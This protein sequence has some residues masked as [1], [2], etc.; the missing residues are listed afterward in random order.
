M[1]CQVKD[2]VVEDRVNVLRAEKIVNILLQ[3]Q[4]HGERGVSYREDIS[5]ISHSELLVSFKG[6]AASHGEA[7]PRPRGRACKGNSAGGLTQKARTDKSSIKPDRHEPLG[8]PRGTYEDSNL[9]RIQAFIPDHAQ[10]FW[11]GLVL[12]VRAHEWEKIS[13]AGEDAKGRVA[14]R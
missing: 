13:S 2:R 14:P 5:G 6:V 3:S 9:S 10:Y 1:H 8:P 7:S 12:K 4:P 11:A